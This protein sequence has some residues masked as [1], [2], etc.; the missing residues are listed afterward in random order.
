[1]NVVTTKQVAGAYY[2]FLVA[3]PFVNNRVQ[4]VQDFDSNPG[5]VWGLGPEFTLALAAHRPST[6]SRPF[7]TSGSLRLRTTTEGGAW[8]L[9]FVFPLT[10]IHLP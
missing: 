1:V 6:G 10:P 3:L 8:N 7:A 2:G 5:A 9:S 4:G